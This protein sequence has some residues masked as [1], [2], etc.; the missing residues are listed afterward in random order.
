MR[1]WF[2]F[3]AIALLTGCATLGGR[4]TPLG[5]QLGASSTRAP[6]A[7]AVAGSDVTFVRPRSTES[8]TG[9]DDSIVYTFNG[10]FG[11]IISGTDPLGFNGQK[12]TTTAT[13]STKIKPLK[14]TT[15]SATY[16]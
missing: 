12:F 1:P 11:P 14:T 3:L 15:A 9:P 13:V 16:S 5:P 10:T 8:A 7:Q 6:S 4:S 2:G